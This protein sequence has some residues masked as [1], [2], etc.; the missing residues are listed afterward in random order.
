[1]VY[2]YAKRYALK[3]A[4]GAVFKKGNQLCFMTWPIDA[5][6]FPLVPWGIDLQISQE[7]GPKSEDYILE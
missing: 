7:E 6:T 5:G 3:S 4:P 2:F 1:M